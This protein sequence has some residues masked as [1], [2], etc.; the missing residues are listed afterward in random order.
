MPPININADG[1]VWEERRVERCLPV[2][3]FIEA[4]R[5]AAEGLE[6]ATV[7]VETDYEY[8]ESYPYIAVTGT[9]AP[10]QAEI[11]ASSIQRRYVEIQQEELAAAQRRI[12]ERLTEETP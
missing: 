10:T 12:Q 11:N 4:L 1:R 5:E 3:D 2:E 8:G 9:R 7:D 6:E